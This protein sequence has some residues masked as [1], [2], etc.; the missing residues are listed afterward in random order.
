MAVLWLANKCLKKIMDTIMPNSFV[1]AQSNEQKIIGGISK[2]LWENFWLM[3]DVKI[4]LIT[5]GIVCPTIIMSILK[6]KKMA[7][8][9]GIAVTL[10]IVVA[11]QDIRPYVIAMTNVIILARIVM[12]IY[13]KKLLIF[14]FN[15]IVQATKT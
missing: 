12:V 2:F 7:D 8:G 11:M 5:V 15:D 14:K 3:Q 9:M 13:S 1:I 4:G 10:G 6:W